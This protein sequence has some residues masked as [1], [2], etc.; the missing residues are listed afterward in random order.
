MAAAEPE[1]PAAPRRRTA[2]C[3]SSSTP[4][5]EPACGPGDIVGAI[6]NEADIPG[7]AI[8]AIDIYDR[9]TFFEV[10]AQHLDRVLDRMERATIRNRPVQ[11][12]VATPEGGPPRRPRGVKPRP[13]KS[14]RH[15]AA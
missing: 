8:G 15:R 9:F 6:A 1:A 11:V 13:G 2:W 3:G 10:P 5:V 7:K 4:A 12:R 14:K